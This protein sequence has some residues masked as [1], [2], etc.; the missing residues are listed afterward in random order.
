MSRLPAFSPCEQRLIHVQPSETAPLLRDPDEDAELNGVEPQ[1]KTFS[2][3]LAAISQEPLTLLTKV[4]LVI[5][6]VLLLLTSVF[7]GLFAG[8]EHKL[9]EI[10]K[11]RDGENGPKP[12]LTVTQTTTLHQT[13][14]VPTG[15]LPTE[16][17]GDVCH[18]AATR[19][20]I[21]TFSTFRT[22]A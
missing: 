10:N 15:P 11:G 6:L 16:V 14:T 17:P 20:A 1:K 19:I 13:E 8:A 3:Q 7:I 22:C 12:T 2:E 18:T 4:L 5:T 21:L 9:K